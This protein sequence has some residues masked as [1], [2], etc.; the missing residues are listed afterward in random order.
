MKPRPRHAAHLVLGLSVWFGWLGVMY[1]GLT[2]GCV[3]APPPPGEGSLT[4]LNAAL[5]ALT[6]ATTAGL[7]GYA[8]LCWRAAQDPAPS[9]DP[10]RRFLPGV[11]AAL[12]LAAALA[13][14]FVGLPVLGLAP[15]V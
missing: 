2:L 14:L 3:L 11:G 12:H 5:V 15:C 13:T 1:A 8:R 7:L 9:A 6:I 10:R 4:W